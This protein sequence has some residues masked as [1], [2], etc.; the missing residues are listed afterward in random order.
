MPLPSRV[1][2]ARLYSVSALKSRMLSSLIA[3][4]EIRR[5]YMHD[6]F[7]CEDVSDSNIQS[8]GRKGK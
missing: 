8:N 4:V 7:L 2:S 6:S 5:D 3:F 1:L